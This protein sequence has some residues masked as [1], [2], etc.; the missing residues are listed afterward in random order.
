MRSSAVKEFFVRVSLNKPPGLMASRL[1]GQACS[2]GCWC[3]GGRSEEAS[4]CKGGAVTREKA[5]YFQVHVKGQEGNATI[6][7]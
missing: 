4:Q 6:P 7:M 3:K 2:P 5:T 1:P